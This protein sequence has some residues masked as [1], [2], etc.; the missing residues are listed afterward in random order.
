MADFITVAKIGE[1]PEGRGKTVMVGDREIAIFCS[2][3]QYYALD[4]Y[5]PHMGASLGQG[6]VQQGAVICDRH[7]W[8][9]RLTD[10]VCLDVSR[11]KAETFEVRVEGDEIQVR[12]K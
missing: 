11:L 7:L 9:F 4:D 1:I 12:P 6:V 5:C 2:G 3:G 10:G 8:A